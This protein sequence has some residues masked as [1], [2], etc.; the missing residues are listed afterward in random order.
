MM[1]SDKEH[2]RQCGHYAERDRLGVQRARRFGPG[3][4]P[5][6]MHKE[7]NWYATAEGRRASSD[8]RL[9]VMTAEVNGGRGCHQ[10]TS[11]RGA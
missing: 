9:S 11:R 5:S 4:P 3:R 10:F 8:E 7:C 1:R 2:C 6:D